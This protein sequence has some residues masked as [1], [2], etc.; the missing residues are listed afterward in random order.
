MRQASAAGDFAELAAAAHRLK[1]SSRSMGAL[2]MGDLCAEIENVVKTANCGA[3]VALM[4]TL[5]ST[6]PVLLDA[7]R[8]A[9][10]RFGVSEIDGR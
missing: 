8:G 3:V 9:L 5:E 10:D 2:P 4:H 7:I 1:S 6:L